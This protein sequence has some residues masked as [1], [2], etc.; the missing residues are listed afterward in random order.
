ME[1]YIG[2]YDEWRDYYKKTMISL[3]EWNHKVGSINKK[4]KALSIIIGRVKILGDI[5]EYDDPKLACN[6]H[7][8]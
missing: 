5:I 2:Y 6:Y 1:K 3:I 7:P 8:F 4:T